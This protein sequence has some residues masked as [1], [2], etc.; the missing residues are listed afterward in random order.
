MAFFSFFFS[1]GVL[2]CFSCVSAFSDGLLPNGN[3]EKAP[4]HSSLKGSVVIGKNSLPDWEIGGA[5]EYVK[6]G[7]KSGDLMLVI[8]EGFAAVRLGSDAFIRQRVSV[9]KGELYALTLSAARTCASDE[10]LNVTVSTDS[11]RDS[12]LIS[13]Q[14]IYNA[15]GWDSYAWAF[16]A[17]SSEIG[18]FIGDPGQDEDPACGSVVDAVALKVLH[19][20][21]ANRGNL[22]KNG[23]FEEG[24]YFLPNNLDG[25]LI[26]PNQIDRNSPLPGWTILSLKSVR[27]IDSPHFS[28]PEG[29]KAVELLAGK[30]SIISQTATTV[31]KA[32]YVLTFLVGDANNTCKGSMAVEAY[33]GRGSL[34]VDYESKGLGGFK[35]AKLVFVALEKVTRFVFYSTFYMTRT[36]DLS[37]LCGPV[38][39]DVRLVPLGKAKHH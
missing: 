36:D 8:P 15:K 14:T 18:V 13:V 11:I 22:L 25:V 3:F 27:Y 10:K 33:A 28:V 32:Y 2:L 20:P 12:G 26:P 6:S 1:L 21:K 34:K 4:S 39:D 23:D 17:E 38:I 37:S 7:Q 31:P 30:E 19:P 24:P 9:N 16:L 29:R 35:R 5:V